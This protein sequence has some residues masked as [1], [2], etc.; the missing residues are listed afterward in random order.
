M[1]TDIA[2]IPGV[3]AAL[4]TAWVSHPMASLVELLA[5]AAHRGGAAVCS[6]TDDAWPELLYA[7]ARQRAL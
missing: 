5:A 4:E 2:R 3:L 7:V 6:V 1:S